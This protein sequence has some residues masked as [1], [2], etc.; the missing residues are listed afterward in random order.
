MSGP[1]MLD[2]DPGVG[3]RPG[4]EPRRAQVSLRQARQVPSLAH[5]KEFFASWRAQRGPVWIAQQLCEECDARLDFDE[6]RVAALFRGADAL[7]RLKVVELLRARAN[8]RHGTYLAATLFEMRDEASGATLAEF[9]RLVEETA[10]TRRDRDAELAEHHEVYVYVAVATSTA[11]AWRH[12]T[13]TWRRSADAG[14]FEA[15]VAAANERFWGRIGEV[16]H[17]GAA[18]VRTR[19]RRG[20]LVSW[21]GDA[22]SDEDCRVSDDEDAFISTYVAAGRSVVRFR[23]ELPQ[24]EAARVFESARAVIRRERVERA[25]RDQ[26][27]SRMCGDYVVDALEVSDSYLFQ[28]YAEALD[29][30]DMDAG[31]FFGPR[32]LDVVQ[33]SPALRLGLEASR[34]LHEVRTGERIEKADG[35]R[36]HDGL[37]I[38]VP[39]LALHMWNLYYEK[40]RG[41]GFCTAV[42]EDTP[43]AGGG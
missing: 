26:D 7:E 6:Q 42:R 33:V 40:T 28:A 9:E 35:D 32:I 37:S 10:A 19:D 17:M 1:Y 4:G 15:R 30:D 25:H 22:P 24:D 16:S 8:L 12:A 13:D 18:V 11:D 41:R 34:W 3:V 5:R 31:S 2:G 27:F 43:L 36:G 14:E 39:R 20:V 29:E 21:H 23:L 38:D